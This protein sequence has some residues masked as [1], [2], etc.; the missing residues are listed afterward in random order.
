ME[1]VR[2]YSLLSGEDQGLEL[3]QKQAI[4]IVDKLEQFRTEIVVDETS[5]TWKEILSN[6]K[7]GIEGRSIISNQ[8]AF[9]GSVATTEAANS[10][11]EDLILMRVQNLLLSEYASK[12]Q[13]GNDKIY[14]AFLDKDASLKAKVTRVRE[15]QGFL[16]T[17]R[18]ELSVLIF[19][20]K[21]Q[22]MV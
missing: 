10:D 13:Q 18:G 17:L 22:K 2:S 3:A 6:V 5:A 4:L 11:R 21:A 14:A 1:K 16:N 12:V 15:T 19:M 7:K 20:I 8:I 9:M